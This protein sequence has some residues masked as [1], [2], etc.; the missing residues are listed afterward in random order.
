MYAI[1]S[2]YAFDPALKPAGVIC[3]QTAGERHRSVLR[4]AIEAHT[5][6]P[7]LGMLPK[8][9][10]NPIPERHMGLWSDREMDAAPILDPLADIISENCDLTAIRRIAS[11]APGMA[12]STAQLFP[13]ITSY[14]IHYTKLY[15]N[16]S[17]K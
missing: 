6:V 8:L 3:N 16:P 1:R 17:I 13:V 9:S 2:Y 4:A 15:E 7:V 14:S 12:E 11:A 10:Q 5:D